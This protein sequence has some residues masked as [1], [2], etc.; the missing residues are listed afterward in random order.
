MTADKQR[1]QDAL[2]REVQRLAADPADVAEARAVLDDFG[3]LGG[4]FPG[5][6]PGELSAHIDSERATLVYEGSIDIAP[7]GRGVR[8]GR[9]GAGPA[10]T[11][12]E[13][14]G[15]LYEAATGAM[16]GHEDVAARITVTLLIDSDRG[17]GR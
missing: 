5:G 6:L 4:E 2:R 8:L 11:L 17:D 16:P 1:R 9:H 7:L 14:V 10:E 3:G 15:R 12:A 13:A